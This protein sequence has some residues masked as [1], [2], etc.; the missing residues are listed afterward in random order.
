MKNLLVYFNENNISLYLTNFHEKSL[1]F[2]EIKCIK[3]LII[4]NNLNIESLENTFNELKIKNS[5]ETILI[6]P[7]GFE[8]I[9]NEIDIKQLNSKDNKIF[10]AVC[11]NLI[12]KNITETNLISYVYYAKTP[13]NLFV[14][15]L[16]IKNNQNAIT[17]LNFLQQRN[18]NLSGIY[19]LTDAISFLQKKQQQ[20]TFLCVVNSNLFTEK[21]NF[22]CEIF[23]V[24]NHILYIRKINLLQLSQHTNDSLTWLKSDSKKIVDWLKFYDTN[25]EIPLI[26]IGLNKLLTTTDFNGLNNH[27]NHTNYNI[28]LPENILNSLHLIP[29]YNCNEDDLLND[30]FANILILHTQKNRNNENYLPNSIYKQN[31]FWK[32]ANL[33]RNFALLL[34]FF[35]IIISNFIVYDY[36]NFQNSNIV[37][38]DL[39]NIEIIHKLAQNLLDIDSENS[40]KNIANL[41]EK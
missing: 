28:K 21:N 6:F 29:K 33:Y 27:N 23:V 20:N 30:L 7:M 34:L 26:Q 2:F 4:N 14:R 19:T 13:T 38:Y 35:A 10:N 8:N 16:D 40:K 37:N 39:K 11:N 5:L 22:I 25:T 1:K 41:V 36:F 32:Y 24:E 3:K 17:L 15:F 9:K 31:K 18:Q 12:N